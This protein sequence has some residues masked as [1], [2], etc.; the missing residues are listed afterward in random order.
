MKWTTDQAFD[1]SDDP[2]YAWA[3][4]PVP[5]GFLN[6]RI[7]CILALKSVYL[8]DVKHV[9]NARIIHACCPNFPD[10][11]WFDILLNK[12]IDLDRIFSGHY[13]LE[14]TPLNCSPLVTSTYPS[15]MYQ[16]CRRT[17]RRSVHMA[18]G[19]LPMLL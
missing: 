9:K 2:A 17:P 15:A 1:N 14:Q 5:T 4:A 10:V 13:A 3:D 19:P 8:N 11:M 16:A 18:S 12:Y 6:P 7:A